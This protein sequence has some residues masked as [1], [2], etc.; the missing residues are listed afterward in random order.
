MTE[1]ITVGAGERKSLVFVHDSPAS[2][3]IVVNLAGEGAS[4]EIDELLRSGGVSSNISVVHLANGTFS[5]IR[6]RGVL[7]RGERSS[8]VARVIIPKSSQKCESSVS[9]KFLLLDRS[10][11][12][13]ATPSLEIEADD[14]KASHS[15]SI[16]PL[17]ERSLFYLESRGISRSDAVEILIDGFIGVSEESK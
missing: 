3:E 16:A 9:Q 13:D 11:R 8:A 12:I 4:V 15:T 14:V 2:K 17:D 10:A 1:E 5:K 6:S 7:R